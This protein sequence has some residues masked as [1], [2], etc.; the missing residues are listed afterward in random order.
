MTES[1]SKVDLYAIDPQHFSASKGRRNVKGLTR[2]ISVASGKGGVGKTTTTVNLAIALSNAG[3]RVLVLDA[4]LG[5]ANVDVILGLSPRFTINDV[6]SGKRL[7]DEV[8]IDG[9]ANISIIPAASGVE[10]MC[11]LTASDKLML[12]NSI[13]GVAKDFDYLLID[14]QAGIGSPVTYFT[15]ASQEI[16]IVINSEPTSLTDAYALMKVLHQNYG[17]KRFLVLANNVASER[18]GEQAFRRLAKVSERF[19]QARLTFVGHILHDSSVRESIMAQ[20]AVLEAFPSG[21]AGRGF[22][23]LARTIDRMEPRHEAKGGM[24][25]FFEKLLGVSDNEPMA[26]KEISV[27]SNVM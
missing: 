23:A 1:K 16:L 10:S 7:I 9:P 26:I 13:E 21:I 25:F 3:N 15:S 8:M 11:H 2:V 6:L 4:D 22:A 12:L 17:E 5:L 19:L 14:T 20:R 18:E 24:Q 27:D